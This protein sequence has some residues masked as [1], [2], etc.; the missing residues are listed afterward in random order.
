MMAVRLECFSAL[1][2]ALS[3]V[4]LSKIR[5][6][7]VLNISFILTRHKLLD[8]FFIEKQVIFIFKF[9]FI[10]RVILIICDIK[11]ISVIFQF[12]CVF[13]SLSLQVYKCVQKDCTSSFK[14]LD[15]FLQHVKTHENEMQYRCHL[16]NKFFQSLYELGVHQYTHSLYPN[17]PVKPGARLVYSLLNL[18][19]HCFCLTVCLSVCLSVYHV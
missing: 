13:F 17:H 5:R 2:R 3:C 18:K 16:C 15:A 4:V 19:N 14:D 9:Y 1:F 10:A 7:R 8:F 12:I 11:D 6:K